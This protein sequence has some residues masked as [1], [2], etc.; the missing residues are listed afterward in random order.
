[1]SG[2]EHETGNVERSP[3]EYPSHEPDR[4]V[5]PRPSNPVSDEAQDWVA[6]QLLMMAEGQCSLAMETRVGETAEDPATYRERMRWL[7]TALKAVL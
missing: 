3:W 7:V 6:R 4:P 2:N 5:T 1:M